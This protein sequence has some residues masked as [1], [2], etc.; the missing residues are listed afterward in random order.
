WH[1]LLTGSGSGSIY[2][3]TLKSGSAVLASSFGNPVAQQLPGP[4][5][6]GQVLVVTMF[7]FAASVPEQAG[8][9]VYYQPI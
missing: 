4:A 7:V 8:E 2:R 6:Q 5:G 1:V 9:L 3:L